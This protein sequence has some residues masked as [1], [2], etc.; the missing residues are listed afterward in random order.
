[1]EKTQVSPQKDTRSHH[2]KKIAEA[3]KN[4]GLPR[5]DG[6]ILTFENFMR[7]ENHEVF[8]IQDTTTFTH[9][10]ANSLNALE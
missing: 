4:L 6:D 8:T 1:M 7:M 9:E 5:D 10:E 3:I 2:K